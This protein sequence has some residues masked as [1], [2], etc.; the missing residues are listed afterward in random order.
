M[1]RDYFMFQPNNGQLRRCSV[2]WDDCYLKTKG[3]VKA[4]CS[5][6]NLCAASGP[7][8]TAHELEK[9]SAT[10]EG[11]IWEGTNVRKYIDL[12]E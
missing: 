6:S 3:F 5:C 12:V 1:V 10:V 7:V 9:K 11:L 8:A 2:Q 4:S